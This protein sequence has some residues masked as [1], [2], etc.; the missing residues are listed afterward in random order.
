M[1]VDEGYIGE[2]HGR[3]EILADEAIISITDL[4]KEYGRHT[5]LSGVYLQIKRGD[6]LVFIGHNGCG[7]STLLKIICGLLPFE[8]GK[9]IYQKNTATAN[10]V[11]AYQATL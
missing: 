6:S 1:A 8:R 7:K 4:V 3:N 5:V 10:M 11:L 2:H 9:A